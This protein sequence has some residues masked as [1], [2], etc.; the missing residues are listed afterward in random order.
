MSTTTTRSLGHCQ[1]CGHEQKIV[2]GRLVRHGY[3]RPGHGQ[4]H[5]RCKGT[6]ASPYEVSCDRLRQLREDRQE[7]LA[8]HESYLT[9]IKRGQV[10]SFTQL[11]RTK[12]GMEQKEYSA[13]AMDPVAF[14]HALDV[15]R[16]SVEREIASDR[17]DIVSMTMRIDAWRPRDVRTVSEHEQERRTTEE[18]EE[19]VRLKQEQ[20][21]QRT[22]RAVEAEGKRVT[23]EAR[24]VVEAA[25]ILQQLR[26]LAARPDH[27]GEAVRGQASR[28][29]KKLRT[30]RYYW[31]WSMNVDR[32]PAFNE[33]LLRLGLAE[34]RDHAEYGGKGT[35]V[36]WLF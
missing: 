17:N 24:R 15:L 9:K 16:S 7:A 29:M 1:V 8:D 22:S 13:R 12:K 35:Y 2:R 21:A 32:D 25:D 31:F 10:A 30:P 34:I 36:H 20:E 3:R 26:E 5:G 23:T 18:R 28:L 6:D 11:V 14:Q 4:I 19:R 33:A 27:Q